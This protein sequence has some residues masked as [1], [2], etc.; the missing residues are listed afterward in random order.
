MLV[1]AGAGSAGATSPGSAGTIAF[2]RIDAVDPD[3]GAFHATIWIT[4]GHG[5][6]RPLVGRKIV[7]AIDIS[8]APDGRTAAFARD[9]SF[10]Y[11]LVCSS[12]WRMN[13]DGS[14]LGMLSD[15]QSQDYCPAW[16]PDGRRIAFEAQFTGVDNGDSG[17]YLMDPDGGSRTAVD[18]NELDGCP[19][20]SPD[21]A[22]LV[23]SR[24]NAL[25][26]VRTDGSG[27]R[28]VAAN[29]GHGDAEPDWSP[30]GTRIAFSKAT[31]TGNLVCVVRANGTD[32]RALAHGDSPAWSPSGRRIA[33]ARGGEIYTVAAAGGRP[34]RATRRRMHTAGHPAWRPR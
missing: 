26:A 6:V 16:S 21:G 8:W 5:R 12:V 3:T 29:V 11:S 28:L 27:Q 4:T 1:L 17:I 10:K 22:Q 9:C 33:F 31:A 13:A 32:L 18:R 20:W 23:F 30:G 14:G 24:G 2:D 34:V 15:G 7:S 19:A 25:Y